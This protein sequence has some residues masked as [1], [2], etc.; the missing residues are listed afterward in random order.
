MFDS[1]GIE[2]KILNVWT[3]RDGET[4][5]PTVVYIQLEMDLQKT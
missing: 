2:V 1:R 3:A 4:L 5:D